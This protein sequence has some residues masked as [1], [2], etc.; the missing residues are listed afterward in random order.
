MR[1]KT[2]NR[3]VV[4]LAYAH[5]YVYPICI[6]VFPLKMGGQNAFLLIG[7]G[8][9]LYAAYSLIGYRLRWKHICCSYQNAYRKEMTPNKINW[10]KIKKTDAYGVPAIFAVIG[11]GIIL[12]HL[13]FA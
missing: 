5:R 4:A 2:Q 10:S 11:V 8:F 6:M 1:E 9:V 12:C 3:I 13:F 7:V